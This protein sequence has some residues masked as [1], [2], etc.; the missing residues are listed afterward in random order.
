MSAPFLKPLISPARF[1]AVLFDLDG[2]ITATD[3]THFTAWKR[4]FDSYLEARGRREGKPLRPFSEDD[5]ATFVDGKPRYEGVRSF[6]ASR[7]I[8]LPEGDTDDAEDAETVHGLGNRK[9]RLFNETIQTHGVTVFEGSLALIHALR[10]AGIR[11]AVVSSSRNCRRVLKAADIESLIDVRFDGINADGL[12]LIGKPNPDTFLKAAEWA[13][14]QPAR[15][16]VVEDAIAGVQAGRAGGFGLVVGVDRAGI[17]RALSE[18]GADIVVKDLS[19][20]LL[21]EA[22]G[23]ALFLKDLPSALDRAD[24]LAR[25]LAG[26]RPAVFLD[27]DGTL[28][29]IVERPELAVLSDSMRR[30]VRDLARR[31]PVAVVSGRDRADVERLVGIDGLVFAGSH[32]FDIRVPG[33]RQI[34]RQEGEDFAPLMETIKARL[35]RE[36]DAIEGALVEPK[37]ASVAV[38][39]RLVT[40]AE[41]PRIAAAVEAILVEHGNVRVTPGKMVYEIQP[42]LDWNKGHAVLWLLEALDLTA[43]DVLPLYFGDDI[44]DEDAFKA[45][46]DRGIG[47]YVSGASGETAEDRPTAADYRLETP[48]E[49]GRLLDTLA[50]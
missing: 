41:R 48:E 27:Y 33:G 4:L 45:L 42:K 16:V 23:M 11:C 44:T 26:R 46:A 40:E 25:R 19:E 39:Y 1:D 21:E 12:N 13:G 10:T 43:P 30:I 34:T 17:G 47:I 35:H 5:M 36:V 37:K 9:N 18:A 28:T 6:L 15:A 49:A 2:V 3:K 20:L 38:H 29:P 7:G 50:R 24:E 32:G 31:C 14:V 8:V 22:R